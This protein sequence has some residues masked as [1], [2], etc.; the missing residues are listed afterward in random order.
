MNNI[1]ESRRPRIFYGWY[2]VIVSFLANCIAAGTGSYVFGLFIKPMTQE[3][4]WSRSAISGVFAVRMVAMAVAGP[5]FGR[6]TDTR[7]GTRTLMALGGGIGGLGLLSLAFT[8][9]LGHFYLGYGFIWGLAMAA[10]SGEVVTGTLLSKWF[11]RMRGRA[12]GLAFMGISLGG[13]ILVPVTVLL[14]NS[15]G[16]R[17]AWIG[18]G[19]LSI[20]VIV[21][22]SLL[23]VH[24][25]PEDIG[26]KPDGPSSIKGRPEGITYAESPQLE[27]PSLTLRQATRQP[28]LW[29][30]VG[31]FSLSNL[32]FGG[33]LIHIFP[34]ITDKGYSAGVAGTIL[35]MIGFIGG[36]VKPAWGL[37]GERVQVRYAVMASF[38]LTSVG[39]ALLVITD[40]GPL[41][42][43]VPVL[44]GIGGGGLSPLMML[45]WANYVGRQSLGT[46]RGMFSP[47][48][49]IASGFSPLFGGYI[50][51]TTNSYDI[52]YIVGFSGMAISAFAILLARPPASLRQ[53]SK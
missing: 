37:L 24:G 48:T 1:R 21:P 45:V 6:F 31:C 23:V 25:A 49:F 27:E 34:Y 40:H 11:V 15:F 3:F 22:I 20:I 42:F 10:L 46:I 4:G 53:K 30:V 7:H 33:L 29:I 39:I 41:I 2:I 13:A 9:S 12:I 52:A 18:L 43:L 26:L 44:Y 16:W 36:I 47:L 32:V 35:F 14:I 38:L 17:G 5:I 19:I 51:D 50:Y 8:T 28:S